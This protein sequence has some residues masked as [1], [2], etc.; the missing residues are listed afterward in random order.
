MNPEFRRQLSLELSPAR[1][2]LMPAILLMLAICVFVIEGKQP[3][4]YL[5][6]HAQILV[7]WLAAGVGTL[8]G[9]LSTNDGWTDRT[10]A[11]NGRSAMG[12]WGT[13][14]GKW[15]G[16]PSYAGYGAFL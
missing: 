1:L 3:L 4:L 16:G 2:V 10:G 14:W 9:L 8:T 6:K 5:H 12:P 7:A 11:Q 13:A 15:L